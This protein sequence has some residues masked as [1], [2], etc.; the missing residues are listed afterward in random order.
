MVPSTC[1]RINSRMQA[2]VAGAERE[3]GFVREDFGFAAPAVAEKRAF[4]GS[5]VAAGG[6]AFAV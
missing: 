3:E 1:Y 4:V 2:N 5:K 6:V